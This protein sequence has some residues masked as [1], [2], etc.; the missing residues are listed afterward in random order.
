MRYLLDVPLYRMVW[1]WLLLVM[2]PIILGMLQG[3]LSLWPLISRGRRVI[4]IVMMMIPLSLR[5]YDKYKSC[6]AIRHSTLY[7]TVEPCVMCAAA[8]HILGI[9][10]VVY[11]NATYYSTL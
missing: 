9:S 7:V 6:D 10:R 4:S 11:G 3:M 8:L 5:I 2:R 1:Y